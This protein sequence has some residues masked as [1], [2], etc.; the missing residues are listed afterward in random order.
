MSSVISGRAPDGFLIRELLV[1]VLLI[2]GYLLIEGRPA[3]QKDK[4]V[5]TITLGKLRSITIGWMGAG[6]S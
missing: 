1:L 5:W 2:D 6:G 4:L 3:L